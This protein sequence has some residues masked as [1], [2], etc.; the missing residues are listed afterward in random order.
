VNGYGSRFTTDWNFNWCKYSE[1]KSEDKT[2]EPESDRW[3]KDFTSGG[4]VNAIG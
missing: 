3:P 4:G 2:L 1:I